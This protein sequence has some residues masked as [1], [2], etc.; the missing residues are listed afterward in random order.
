M[1]SMKKGPFGDDKSGAVFDDGNHGGVA[2]V[3]VGE[4]NGHGITYLV[5]VKLNE[6]DSIGDDEPFI[7]IFLSF[8]AWILKVIKA[9]LG[10]TALVEWSGMLKIQKRRSWRNGV[11]F[12]RWSSALPL[13]HS[14]LGDDEPFI[15]IFLSLS[16]WILKMRKTQLIP[17][18][19][20]P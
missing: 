17:P 16:A 1:M 15:V 3:I 13:S 20:F 10:V 5:F 2:R 4:D 18:F 11:G 14:K 9:F 6:E 7:V 12:S 19:S 8:S